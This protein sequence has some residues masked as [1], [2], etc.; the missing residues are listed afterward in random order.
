MLPGNPQ[1][2]HQ[3]VNSALSQF[4]IVGL[5]I[6]RSVHAAHGSLAAVV[7]GVLGSLYGG[8]GVAQ[9]AQNALNTVWAIPRNAR[10]NS[11]K[12]RLRSLLLLAVLGIGLLVTTGLSGLTTGSQ[13]SGS[14]LGGI[15]VRVG[16]TVLAVALNV[17]LFIVA[18][19]V[20][21]AREVSVREVRAGAVAAAVGWQILQTVGTYFVSHKLKGASASY[22]VFG[23]VL[24]LIALVHLA[25][26]LLVACV[27]VNVVRAKKL[28]PRSLLTPFTDNVQLTD[29]DQRAYTSYAQAQRN[30]GFEEIHTHFRPPGAHP[31]EHRTAGSR[32]P[33]A[34]EPPLEDGESPPRSP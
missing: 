10:P 16:A 24:G 3:V 26:L 20:L 4:P 17:L 22:G 5:Q 33:P 15:A 21:T 29:E 34:D 25:A 14:E 11:I 32:P 27:E 30:K 8:I 31:E 12:S 13:A 9:A 18:F 2:Q 6:G 7:I 23:A 28:W 19:R 1:L